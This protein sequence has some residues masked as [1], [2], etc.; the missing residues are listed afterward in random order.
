LLRAW[1]RRVDALSVKFAL[2]YRWTGWDDDGICG[3][4]R[5]RPVAVEA[6]AT[7]WRLAARAGLGSAPMPVV[8]SSLRRRDDLAA[9]TRQLRVHRGLVGHLPRPFRGHAEGVALSFGPRT[10][11]GEAIITRSGIE[12]G[13]IYALSADLRDAVLASGQATLHIALRPDLTSSADA[14]LSAPKQNSRCRTGCARRRSFRLSHRPVAGAAIASGAS[15]SSLSPENLAGL[16]NAAPINSLVLPRSRARSRP[17]RNSVRRA[18]SGFMLRRLPGLR[19]RRNARLGSADR[20]YLLQ[21][22]FATGAAAGKG[23]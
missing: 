16:I 18:R 12:G 3:F 2:R 17:R 9:K 20:R 5:R 22:S 10:V 11:R 4:R 19:R 1:L 8:E 7:C 21:A 13:A 23:R 14:R 15:L 6:R